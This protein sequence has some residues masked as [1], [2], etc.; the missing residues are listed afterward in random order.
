MLVGWVVTKFGFSL[1]PE[2]VWV[3]LAMP[4]ILVIPYKIGNLFT[5][6]ITKLTSISSLTKESKVTDVLL[7]WIV[8]LGGVVLISAALQALGFFYLFF[9][10]LTGLL[11]VELIINP[12][13]LW[14][15]QLSKVSKHKIVAAFVACAIGILP[16]IISLQF[17]PYPLFGLNHDSA[18]AI[19]QPSILAIEDQYLML[20][21]RLPEVMLISIPSFFFNLDPISVLWMSRFVL[22]FLFAIG[23]FLY[24]Q[25]KVKDLRLSLLAVL[26]STFILTGGTE[27]TGMLF[28]DVPAQQFKG[29]TILYA[30]FP[31]TLLLIDQKIQTQQRSL[32]S[33]IKVTFLVG[34]VS[35]LLYLFLLVEDQMLALPRGMLVFQIRPLILPLI[36]VTSILVGNKL[37]S[38]REN[39][40]GFNILFMISFVFILIHIHEGLLTVLA[41]FLYILLSSF[42]SWQKKNLTGIVSPINLARIA[43][44]FVFLYVLLQRMDIIHIDSVTIPYLSAKWDVGFSFKFNEFVIGTGALI[45]AFFILSQLYLLLVKKVGVIVPSLIASIML[46]GYFSPI[47]WGYRLFRI[48]NPFMTIMIVLLLYSLCKIVDRPELS[49]TIRK[50]VIPKRLSSI[51]LLFLVVGLFPSLFY[52]VYDR[53]AFRNEFIPDNQPAQTYFL[54]AEYEAA[55]FIREQ[56]PRN[57]I[58]VSDY[59]S[60]WLLTPISNSVWLID[61]VMEVEEMNNESQETLRFLKKDILR[62]ESSEKAYERIHLLSNRIPPESLYH[63]NDAGIENFTFIVVISTRTSAWLSQ[64]SLD[65]SY[66]TAYS[67]D[68][69]TFNLFYNHRYFKLLQQIDGQVYI[70]E[71]IPTALF[72]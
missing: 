18:R 70:F 36:F 57:T 10:V 61:R 30:L 56:M 21:V 51:L 42:S 14:S 15:F 8:G 17:I 53:F 63:I 26:I 5:F 72:Q 60:M 35:L 64:D 54:P 2:Y 69:V 49:L 3:I 6:L 1:I 43:A 23:I 66:R 31:L 34:F 58:I 37:F 59:F 7:C 68:P 41:L 12:T 32:K 9:Y 4:L 16:L 52:P 33:M 47:I 25:E 62:A 24:C 39:R 13:R 28:F 11:L 20:D 67:I 65:L 19:I 46:F 40:L 29:T 22:A 50:K 48:I 44:V 55:I 38:K 45:L 27:P 71:V